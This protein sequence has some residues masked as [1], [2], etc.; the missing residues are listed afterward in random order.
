MLFIEFHS[1]KEMFDEYLLIISF[2]HLL[3]IQFRWIKNWYVRHLFTFQIKNQNTVSQNKKFST[4]NTLLREK[5][6]NPNIFYFQLRL[7]TKLKHQHQKKKRYTFF[8]DIYKII[9]VH[10]AS[11]N[12]RFSFIQRSYLIW[13]ISFIS[14]LHNWIQW[15]RWI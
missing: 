1:S 5:E 13:T 14:E 9:N 15:I 11:Y 7:S 4:L 8:I 10:Q 3:F 2:F 12:P 6:E